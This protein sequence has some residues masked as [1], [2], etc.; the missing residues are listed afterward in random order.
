MHFNF[1]KLPA[2]QNEE[3]A[4]VE[5]IDKT[6]KGGRRAGTRLITFSEG[7]DFALEVKP[8]E[9]SN[10]DKQMIVL[11]ELCDKKILSGHQLASP[12]LAGISVSGQLGGNTELESAFK[13]FDKVTIEADRQ[14]LTNSL[15]RVL[16][17]N[18]I[19]VIID[20][21]PFNPFAGVVQAQQSSITINQVRGN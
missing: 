8:I 5:N 1:L 3:D 4:I 12:L 11:A 21:N 13:I 15:Q 9:T 17:Y 20:V 10:L 2:S 18:N 14:L 6:F 7:K 19:P 16:D